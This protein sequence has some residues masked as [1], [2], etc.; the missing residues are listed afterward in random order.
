[1]VSAQKFSIV[2]LIF[3]VGSDWD[4]FDRAYSLFKKLMKKRIQ[5]NLT[6]VL[7]EVK[8]LRMNLKG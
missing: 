4:L 8:N 5:N 1:M 7:L 3:L 6:L 2:V